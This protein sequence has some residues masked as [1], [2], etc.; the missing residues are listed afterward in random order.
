[1]GEIIANETMDR[2]LTFKIYRQFNIR[3]SN[4]PIKNW[5]EVLNRHFSKEDIQRPRGTGKDAQH[6]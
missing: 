2:E 6:R 5:S 1:M 4:K 3:K